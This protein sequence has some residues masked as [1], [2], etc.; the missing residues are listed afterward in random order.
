VLEDGRYLEFQVPVELVIF[1]NAGKLDVVGQS[2]S[3]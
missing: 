1:N 3:G 2:L